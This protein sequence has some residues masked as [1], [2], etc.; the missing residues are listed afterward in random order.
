MNIKKEMLNIRTDLAYDEKDKDDKRLSETIETIDGI[1]IYKHIIDEE[2]AKQYN[3][4][5]GT[6]YTIDLSDIDIRDTKTSITIEKTLAKVLKN[7][8]NELGLTNKK[9]LI[10]G[11]GNINVTPD[12]LGPYVVD[13][14]IVTRH[15]FNLN[16]ISEGFS[17]V[18]AISPGVMGTTGIE[19]FDI[20]SSV[21]KEIECDYVIAVDAL[22]TSSVARVNK[23][24]QIADSGINPGSGVG[25][26]RKELS[27]ETLGIP[28]IAIGVPTVVD[29]VTITSYV[30]DHL[31]KYLT[32]INEKELLGDFGILDDD[33]KRMLIE[34]V[35][36][37]D[38]IN[39]MVTPKEIDADIEELSKILSNA[40]DL[41]LHEGLF[42]GMSE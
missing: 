15:L 22:A 33:Q 16:K 2:K 36:E 39:M 8:I 29:S 23:T 32:K 6:Y 31:L 11:L 3:K 14:V 19:T 13:N 40:I 20:I 1:E 37:P 12:A 42:N 34:G 41:S 26:K 5:C 7:I 24:I 17:N 35:L 4:K 38:G 25:N 28:V 9:C 10:V 27:L 18:S 21:V 30:I